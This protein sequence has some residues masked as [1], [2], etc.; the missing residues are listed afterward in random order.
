MPEQGR[1]AAR[2][3]Y[4]LTLPDVPGAAEM[5]VEPP[6]E[7]PTWGIRHQPPSQVVG[8]C[9]K[10]EFVSETQ[11]RLWLSGGGHVLIDRAAS[12]STLVLPKRPA[13]REIVH[14]FLAATAAVAA[15]WRGWHCFHA[16]GLVV[17]GGAWGVLGDKGTGKSSLLAWLARQGED[18][19]CDDVLVID[20]DG[21]AVTGPRSLDL[22]GETAAWLGEGEA[23]GVVGARARWRMPLGPTALSVPLRGWVVL[24]W[25]EPTKVEEVPPLERLPLLAENLSLRLMPTNGQT[26][27]DLTV[28]PL[29]RLRRPRRLDAMRDGA[30][31]LLAALGR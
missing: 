2:G 15:R 29:L 14:P 19:L 1:H 28:L 3:A 6:V 13:D 22:R 7:W 27:M 25:G 30:E 20:Q 24:A 31:R 5:L 12:M 10:P 4:G 8:Y 17:D 21:A 18:V 23:L 26:L 9:E 11:G 16:G